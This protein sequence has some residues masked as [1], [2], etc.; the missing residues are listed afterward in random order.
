MTAD[1]SLAKSEHV[2]IL[3]GANDN[4][5]RHDVC[6]GGRVIGARIGFL[7]LGLA[8]APC[9]I[10]QA[11]G[12]R[13][14]TELGVRYWLSTGE[15]RHSHN[16]QS[17]DPT[18][19]NPTSVLVYENL[20]ASV[21]EVFGRY[22]F[23]GNWFVKGNLGLGVVNTGSFDDQDFEAGQ[24]TDSH[25]TSSVPSGWIAHGTIDLGRDEWALRQ[26]RAS[27]GAFVGYSR[28]TE[29][30]DVYGLTN[31]AGSRDV[32]RGVNVIS[33]ELSWNALRVGLAAGFAFN[34]RTR[35]SADLA[36]VPYATFRNE[37]SHYLR[38]TD[39]TSAFYLGPVPNI[40][41]DGKGRGVQ[42][43]VELIHEVSQRTELGLGLRYWRLEATKG[44]RTV[45]H[46]PGAAEL[47][48]VELV[49]QRVGMLFSLRTRW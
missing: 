15:N 1:A 9:A 41:I 31:Q 49:S 5:A 47:P 25:T 28:W 35:F 7:I 40:L 11:P 42:L 37:D 34:S 2:C 43:D 39:P 22:N 4:P 24:V 23:G 18:L 14:P 19:G 29:Y 44:T 36:L 30:L 6:K 12:P 48:L 32:D 38:S 8:L 20:D 13:P 46:I 33:N 26:G 27:L 17:V 45:P 10:A 3:S 16:A 21:V